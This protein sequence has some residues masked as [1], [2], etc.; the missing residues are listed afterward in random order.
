MAGSAKLPRYYCTVGTKGSPQHST[1]VKY[2]LTIVK[3]NL[4]NVKWH[5]T[6]VN[7][8]TWNTGHP[9]PLTEARAGSR[10]GRNATAGTEH[11]REVGADEAPC[12]LSRGREPRRERRGGQRSRGTSGRGG[13]G[14]NGGANGRGKG[15]MGRRSRLLPP[16]RSGSRGV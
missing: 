10:S 11:G 6:N 1:N 7:C 4:T 14:E 15:G 13:H 16:V 2:H 12:C 9:A 5:L 8:S 3:W